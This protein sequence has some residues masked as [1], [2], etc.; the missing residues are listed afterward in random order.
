MLLLLLLLVLVLVLVLVLRRLFE[1]SHAECGQGEE[2][3]WGCWETPDVA[4]WA[5]ST[6]AAPWE[7][8]LRRLGAPEILSQTVVLGPLE[9]LGGGGLEARAYGDSDA[10]QLVVAVHGAN[11]ALVDEWAS[12]AQAV[13]DLGGYH[14]LLVNFH[15]H[16]RTAPGHASAEDFSAAILSILK[17]LKRKSLV[18]MGK[19]WGG[20]MAVRFAASHPQLVRRLV[21]SAPAVGSSAEEGEALRALT[22]PVLLAWS[23][24]D[25]VVPYSTHEL[26][27]QNVPH[28]RSV[29]YP[30]GGH[31][32]N[33]RLATD[34][35]RFL[36]PGVAGVAELAKQGKPASHPDGNDDAA[37][38]L[39][40]HFQERL[41]HSL[42]PSVAAMHGRRA[43]VWEDVVFEAPR[44]A[45]ARLPRDA[46]VEVFKRPRFDRCPAH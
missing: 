36:E 43:V 18:L 4:A 29:A 5:A 40:A 12:V 45:A 2:V 14:V 8:S 24:D 6:P 1:Y 32:I 39:F 19:S 26:F 31:R 16:K 3:H 9:M 28:V 22:M 23:E 41:H 17:M 37:H 27:V 30:S 10:A 11:P 15:S 13:G 20:K 46:I 21:L 42:L 35:V 25:T 34:V 38:R 7:R 33:E 44:W